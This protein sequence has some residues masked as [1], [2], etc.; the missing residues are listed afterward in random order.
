MDSDSSSVND[1]PSQPSAVAGSSG[2]NPDI[3]IIIK[4]I[5]SKNFEFFI[6]SDVRKNV[7][8]LFSKK[9][10]MVFHY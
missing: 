4:T 10:L 5:D 2:D 8:M 3:L 9:I 7:F 1:A 6:K